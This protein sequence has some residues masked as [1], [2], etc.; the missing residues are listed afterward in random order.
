MASESPLKKA[1]KATIFT[2]AGRN[3]ESETWGAVGSLS[4]TCGSIYIAEAEAREE[5]VGGIQVT[6]MKFADT[7]TNQLVSVV[8]PRFGM[9]RNHQFEVQDKA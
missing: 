3:I 6:T 4:R 8:E 5:I 1:S 9:I 2:A 7:I